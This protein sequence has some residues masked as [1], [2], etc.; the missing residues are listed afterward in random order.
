[1]G[2]GAGKCATAVT[3][4]AAAAA[5][6]AA[7]AGAAAVRAVYVLVLA[8][9]IA[10]AVG[11][12]CPLDVNNVWSFV[13]YSFSHANW[14]HLAFNMLGLLTFG[15]GIEREKGGFDFLMVYFGAIISG[16]FLHLSSGGGQVVGASAGIF[17]LLVCYG[18]MFPRRKVMLLI[19]PM[20]ALA[21]VYW[22]LGLEVL[23]T[24]MGWAP[25]VAHWAHLGG[26]M[27]GLGWAL[28]SREHV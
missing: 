11:F 9:V 16:A 3:L 10:F 21:L 23:A 26:A 1:M 24:F 6:L 19:F 8:N 14:L 28:G 15:L 5:A 2:T 4:A 18:I 25:G 22:Y 12:V 7:A 13:G 17:G 20:S 27:Y